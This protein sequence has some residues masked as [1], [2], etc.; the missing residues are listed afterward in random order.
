LAILLQ[1]ASQAELKSFKRAPPGRLQQVDQLAKV[2]QTRDMKRILKPGVSRHH[3]LAAKL[4]I[5]L[6]LPRKGLTSTL[7]HSMDPYQTQHI[8]EYH[9]L[10]KPILDLRDRRKKTGRGEKKEGQGKTDGMV[11]RSTK[12]LSQSSAL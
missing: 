5:V 3:Y 11:E 2:V 7:L 1:L 12:R 9:L 6:S 8:V 10:Q 4:Q